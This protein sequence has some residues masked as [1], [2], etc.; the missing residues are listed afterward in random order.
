MRII[1]LL[2]ALIGG[3]AC[4]VCGVAV[5]LWDPHTGE[6]LRTFPETVKEVGRLTFS[7][8]GKL[9]ASKV[10]GGLKEAIQLWDVASG[11][12][13]PTRTGP[14]AGEVHALAF[15]PGGTFLAASV[16]GEVKLWAGADLLRAATK[17]K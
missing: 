17:D 7:P 8:D 3:L 16:G 15:S 4:A 6:A 11:K 14:P 2:F 1:V 13:L 12:L 5:K 10:G 9:L